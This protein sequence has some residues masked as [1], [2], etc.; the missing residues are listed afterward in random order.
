MKFQVPSPKHLWHR[1]TINQRASF[2][3]SIPLFC[4][5]VSL[6]AYFWMRHSVVEA[7]KDIDHTN[8]VLLQSRDIS[9]S[10]LNA[11]SA[12]RG[13]YISRQTEFLESY[14]QTYITLP[15]SLTKL[16]N[17]VQDSPTQTLRSREIEQLA[18]QKMAA[19]TQGIELSANSPAIKDQLRLG[20]QTMDRFNI[21]IEQFE[22]EE[23]RLLDLRQVNYDFVASLNTLAVWSGAII[24]VLGTAVSVRLFKDLTKDLRER[25]LHLRESRNLAQTI[26]GNVV[27]GVVVIDGRSRIESLN[28]AALNMFGYT[29]KDVIG[30]D[31]HMLISSESPI[32]ANQLSQVMGVR[33]NEARF[34]VEISISNIELDDR[35]LLIIRDITERQR[36]AA[37]LQSRSDELAK[38]NL[39]LVS[40]NCILSDR[41]QELDQFA[42]I[43]S[44]DLKA[45]LR[46]I[47]NLSEWLET[48]LDGKLPAENQL[49]LQLL[50]ARVHRMYALLDGVLEYARIGRTEIALETVSVESLLAEIVDTLAPPPSFKMEFGSPL[51]TFMTS[52]V[53]L[54][55]VLM[56]LIDNALKYH[57]NPEQVYLQVSVEEF[58]EYYEFAVTD[59]GDGI[60]PEFHQRIFTIFQTLEAKDDRESTGVGLAIVKKIVEREGGKVSLKSEIG[61]GSTFSFTWRKF[62]LDFALS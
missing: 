27:D 3:L 57:P 40:A 23:L 56:N 41:N 29:T 58:E 9:I 60:D 59:N 28:N 47:S 54:R 26:V 32:L 45:P 11:E 46:A 21:A 38:L 18:Q 31:W 44:H 53:L 35:Q 48:D 34:P 55:Q 8:R 7:Q 52:R 49:Q 61:K 1:L 50:R 17:L 6:G 43:I 30:K 36:A 5:M 22:R 14:E 51:P 4:L 39:A 2:T 33:H 19:L 24:S 10:L 20:K 16:K 37:Q 13:Y 25:E 15:Q 42:Y 62:V 12:V